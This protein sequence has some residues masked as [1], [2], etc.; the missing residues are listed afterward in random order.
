MTTT[1]RPNSASNNRSILSLQYASRNLRFGLRM[2]LKHP[3][4]SCTVLLTLALG[5]GANTAM[6]TRAGAAKRRGC[7]ADYARLFPDVWSAAS[8]RPRI[9]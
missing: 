9:H 8:E 4:L 6:F 5:I 7:T 2:L 1:V 3:A